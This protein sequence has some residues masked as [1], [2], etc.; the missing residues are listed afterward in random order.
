MWLTQKGYDKVSG[1]GKR[2]IG[3]IQPLLK[4]KKKPFFGS[5]T[6]Y[7]K[8]I[9]FKKKLQSS[10]KNYQEKNSALKIVF[11]LTKKKEK[12]K[13]NFKGANR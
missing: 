4:N 9:R 3:P 1:W 7:Y 11:L 2:L 13:G 12:K 8:A 5:L 10:I 6:K